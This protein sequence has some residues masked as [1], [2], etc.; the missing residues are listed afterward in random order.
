MNIKRLIRCLATSAIILQLV[1]CTTAPV[2]QKAIAAIEDPDMVSARLRNTYEAG[3]SRVVAALPP[4]ATEKTSP[5]FPLAALGKFK[6]EYVA[7]AKLNGRNYSAL[8]NGYSGGGWLAI[9]PQ[10]NEIIADMLSPLQMDP[11]T[12][13]NVVQIKSEEMTELWA[14]IFLTHEL[15]HLADRIY[16]IEPV[17]PTR[18]E[19]LMGE[20]RAYALEL[21]AA[22]LL[23][24]GELRNT[25]DTL[26]ARWKPANL[27]E[28]QARLPAM[29]QEDFALLNSVMQGGEPKSDAEVGLRAGFY[30]AALLIRF[31]EVN[32]S[33]A[34][35]VPDAIDL[36]M[37][38]NSVRK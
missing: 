35:R 13:L 10:G 23:A 18:Q 26:I 30:L 4:S 14:G 28:L 24:K 1:A 5:N 16:G 12:T 6:R 17:V 37:K 27:D 21:M 3:F 11:S 38:S 33:A 36:L 15:S 20:V 2:Q 29:T 25:L 19:F 9:V 31:S 7:W 22:D 8:G 34:K 32:P